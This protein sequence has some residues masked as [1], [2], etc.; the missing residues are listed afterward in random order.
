MRKT[1]FSLV[2]ILPQGLTKQ[3]WNEA[4]ST[5]LFPN[6]TGIL[7]TSIETE[8]S[9]FLDILM[10]ILRNRLGIWLGKEC[11]VLC[12]VKPS[13]PRHLDWHTHGKMVQGLL[14][15]DKNPWIWNLCLHQN[16]WET[17]ALPS[18]K[19]VL[20]KFENVISQMI[21]FMCWQIRNF[22]V[23]INLSTLSLLDLSVLWVVLDLSKHSLN[24]YL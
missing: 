22:I 5:P 16:S 2:L 8:P 23:F 4:V 10:E 9:I 13:P 1:H 19:T 15:L 11:W 17:I 21:L 24:Q 20:W 12:T 14:A 7:K 3:S 6:H 18:T